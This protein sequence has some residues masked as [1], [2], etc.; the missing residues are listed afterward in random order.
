MTEKVDSLLIQSVVLLDRQYLLTQHLIDTQ[1]IA[2]QEFEDA[3]SSGQQNISHVLDVYNYAFALIDHLVRYQKIAFSIPRLSQKTPEYRA[4]N[5]SMAELKDMRNQHQHINND[6]ENSY[7]GPLLGSV[8]WV[9]GSKQYTAG[10]HDIGRERSMPGM[11]LDTRTGTFVRE[12]CYVYNE[13]YHD[14]KKAI[15]G[16]HT[17][18]QYI[19]ALVKITIDGKPYDPKDHFVAFCV[20]FKITIP[21]PT[22][23]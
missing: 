4:L 1:G 17:F 6:I 13:K 19:N 8:S 12:F 21:E 2:L 18:N 10:F 5:D 3:I 14:L 11:I 9:S 22:Q 23:T 16:M 7:T 20:E 15:L